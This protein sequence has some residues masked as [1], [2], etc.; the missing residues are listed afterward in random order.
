MKPHF[1]DGFYSHNG[2]KYCSMQSRNGFFSIYF[3]AQDKQKV[4]HFKKS[5]QLIWENETENSFPISLQFH[6]SEN[7]LV[8]IFTPSN[9]SFLPGYYCIRVGF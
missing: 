3:F 2:S 8:D 1:Y 6:P 5:I 7:I 4:E 9:L